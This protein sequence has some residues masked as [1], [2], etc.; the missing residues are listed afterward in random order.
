MDFQF[1]DKEEDNIEE[2]K[3]FFDFIKEIEAKKK[4]GEKLNMDDSNI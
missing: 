1:E 3:E 2:M 4:R